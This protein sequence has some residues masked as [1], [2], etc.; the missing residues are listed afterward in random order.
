MSTLIEEIK[1]FQESSIDKIPADTLKRMEQATK[2]LVESDIAKGLT[3]NEQA[4][5]FTLKDATGTSITL[6]EE[7]KEGPVILTFYRGGW[8]PY[9][10]LE[11]KAYQRVLDDIKTT[12]AKLIAISPQTPDASLT[13]KEKN[14]LEF[15]VLSDPN[16][17]VAESYNLVFKLPDY[18]V[19]I[20]KQFGF[21]IPRD[22]NNDSWEL[23]VPATYIID[24][25]GKIRFASVNPDYTK[26]AEP[27]KVVEALKEID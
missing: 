5:D 7:L 18:L 3:V 2:E 19:E 8:C 14:E 1:K 20:Y 25:T 9:C 16:G 12:G 27:S 22:N 11:L 15:L 4:Q 10:N 21:D 17:N 26:R 24:Q 23:P 6:Y 13:T